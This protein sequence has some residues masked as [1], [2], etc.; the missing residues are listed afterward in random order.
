[1]TKLNL[2][3]MDRLQ[4]KTL[5]PKEGRLIEMELVTSLKEKVRF[6]P[7]EIEEF[8]LRDLPNGSVIWNGAKAK[9]REYRF[10]DSEITVLQ[11]GSSLAD[12]EAKITNDNLPLA[13]RILAIKLKTKL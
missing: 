1:M 3:V 7:A 13:K 6:S 2:S 9:E 12:Q 10:E 11:R 8:E 5:L 4:F